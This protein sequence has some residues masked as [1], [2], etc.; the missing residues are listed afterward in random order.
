MHPCLSRAPPDASLLLLGAIQCA[1][2]PSTRRPVCPWCFRLPSYAPLVLPGAALC[3]L[4]S[5]GRCPMHLVLLGAALS[6]LGPSG[7]SPMHPS[8]FQA[9]LKAPF[10]RQVSPNAPLSSK[11]V[12]TTV[13]QYLPRALTQR[14]LVLL[15]HG[16]TTVSRPSLPKV[17][18]Q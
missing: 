2:G 16:P 7:G 12:A 5:S 8:S 11:G 15:F 10:L 6:T 3:T 17:L 14:R 1:F 9:P 13:P 18:L 4:D